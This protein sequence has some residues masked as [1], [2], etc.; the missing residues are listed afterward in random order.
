MLYRYE[1]TL[2]ELERKKFMGTLAFCLGILSWLSIRRC[3][4]STAVI[5]LS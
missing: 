4:P 2:S 3:R 5:L 1:T